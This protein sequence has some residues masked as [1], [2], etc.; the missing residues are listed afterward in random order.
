MAT[1]AS[2]RGF[3]P[4]LE[5]RVGG[6]IG[7]WVLWLAIL[8]GLVLVAL[9][10]MTVVSV[11]GRGTSS[12]FDVLGPVRGDFELVIMGTAIAVFAFLPYAQYQRGH[13]AVEIATQ[14][15]SPR[16]KAFLAMIANALMSA[17]AFLIAWRLHVGLLDKIDNGEITFIVGIPTW[18]AYA[19]CA[20]GAWTM[21]VASLYTVWRSLNEWRGEGER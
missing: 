11:V 10:M 21:V 8:G 4:A 3:A 12:A 7:R 17:I 2:S 14:W 15:A 16:A 6:I 19:G 9:A 13:V 18:W 20:V 5:A 1:N